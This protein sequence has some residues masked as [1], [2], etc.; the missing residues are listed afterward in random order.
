M[1]MFKSKYGSVL[2]VILVILIV[3]VVLITIIF[4]IKTY[5]NYEDKKSKSVIYDELVDDDDYNTTSDDNTT[6]NE[7]TGNWFINTVGGSTENTTNT[8]APGGTENNKRKRIYYK[9]YPVVGYI[10]IAKTSVDYP[11]LLDIS[12][13]ALDTAVGVMYPSN[14]KLNQPGNVVIIGHNYRNNKF[15]SNNKKLE[16]GDEIEITD[17]NGKTLTYKIYEK[18]Q[19]TE[20]DTEFITRDRGD[21]IEI[22]LS[23]CT[24]DAKA[25]LILLARAE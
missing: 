1:K 3:L 12:P 6:E 13:G 25:R 22:S 20:T 21:N 8:Q 9:D 19:T 4:G 24:D 17:L 2:T 7:D 15:F 18:F 23:T 5:K 10:K 11:I 16:I 14:P